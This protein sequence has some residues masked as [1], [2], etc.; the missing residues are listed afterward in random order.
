MTLEEDFLLVFAGGPVRPLRSIPINP[1]DCVG[2]LA[3][4]SVLVIF[5][6]RASC[7]DW[8]R[9]AMRDYP[10]FWHSRMSSL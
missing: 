2:F 6:M 5:L 10:L 8:Y 7:S 9:V 3:A 1:P 4:V